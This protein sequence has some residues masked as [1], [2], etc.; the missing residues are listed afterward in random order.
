MSSL[1]CHHD[2]ML[3]ASWEYSSCRLGAVKGR[4]RSHRP[5]ISGVLCDPCEYWLFAMPPEDARIDWLAGMF[6]MVQAR[7]GVW[8]RGGADDWSESIVSF[9]VKLA[10][11]IKGN[12]PR[13]KHPWGAEPRWARVGSPPPHCIPGLARNGGF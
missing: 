5:K 12:V 8:V 6:V 7:M 4:R 9:V 3:I 10:K 13:R 2:A 11:A 1:A